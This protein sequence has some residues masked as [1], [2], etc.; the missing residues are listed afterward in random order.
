VT[1]FLTDIIPPKTNVRIE[2][3][4]QFSGV[5]CAVAQVENSW[6]RCGASNSGLA[7]ALA[8]PI[9]LFNLFYK[10]QS[11]RTRQNAAANVHLPRPRARGFAMPENTS[12]NGAE[13]RDFRSKEGD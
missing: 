11:P 3:L 5:A 13:P 7:R 10:K 6:L 12:Q 9:Y 1:D 8:Q 2:N 4:P